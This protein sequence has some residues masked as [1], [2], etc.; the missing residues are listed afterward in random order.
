MYGDWHYRNLTLDV[1]FINIKLKNSQ[2]VVD[3]K[4]AIAVFSGIL[5]ALPPCRLQKS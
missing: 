1:D 4:T 5:A 3:R 2:K